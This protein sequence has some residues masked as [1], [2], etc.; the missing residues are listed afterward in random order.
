MITLEQLAVIVKRS[1]EGEGVS[2]ILL[3]LGI[4]AYEG[5]HYLRDH[6][7]GEIAGAKKKQ[8][9]LGTMKAKQEAKEKG[10]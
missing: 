1:E 8:N 10:G 7:H 3:D 4:P 6:H 5:L 2:H 9:E